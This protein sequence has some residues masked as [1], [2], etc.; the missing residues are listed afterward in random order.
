MSYGQVQPF[1]RFGA[2][3]RANVTIELLLRFDDAAGFDATTVVPDFFALSAPAAGFGMLAL[4]A[5]LEIL[6]IGGSA[7]AGAFRP[8]TFVA[9][10]AE[11]LGFA[12]WLAGEEA[13][14]VL[15]FVTVGELAALEMDAVRVFTAR[16]PTSA[17]TSRLALDLLITRVTEARLI[18]A[19]G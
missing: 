9:L 5:A 15:V 7:L 2:R 8:T 13:I 11:A 17:L 6:T 3:T 18:L 14:L 10:V 12:A 4:F 16:S 19:F 1:P